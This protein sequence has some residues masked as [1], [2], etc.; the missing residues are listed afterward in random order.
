MN[1]KRK[2]HFQ[3]PHSVWMCAFWTGLKIH[4]QT[5]SAS[6]FL[7]EDLKLGFVPPECEMEHELDGTECW[8]GKEEVCSHQQRDL[9]AGADMAVFKAK[10]WE[11]TVGGIFNVG[12]MCLS[13]SFNI[14]FRRQN[15]HNREL[16]TKKCQGLIWSLILNHCMPSGK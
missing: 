13:S 12:T 1:E 3:N 11:S 14:F 6:G 16:R 2:L 15:L 10:G 8:A 5:R 9:H 7:R 4:S